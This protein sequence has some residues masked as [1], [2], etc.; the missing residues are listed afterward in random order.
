MAS[1]SQVLWWS[2][3][4]QWFIFIHTVPH[5]AVGYCVSGIKFSVQTIVISRKI[6]E[7]GWFT[8]G[9]VRHFIAKFPLKNQSIMRCFEFIYTKLTTC[10]KTILIVSLFQNQLMASFLEHRRRLFNAASV[11]ENMPISN[12]ESVRR[13]HVSAQFTGPSCWL[14]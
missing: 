14:V 8:S 6:S 2:I 1:Q 4:D 3:H 11:R 12:H 10:T 13:T 5:C 9:V 7:S